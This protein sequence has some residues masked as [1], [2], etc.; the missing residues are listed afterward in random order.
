MVK[1]DIR[2]GGLRNSLGTATSSTLRRFSRILQS[3]GK[4]GLAFVSRTRD[5]SRLSGYAV[6]TPLCAD[7]A[8]RPSL[9]NWYEWSSNTSFTPPDL[10]NVVIDKLAEDTGT[11]IGTFA[12]AAK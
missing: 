12:R 3:A 1:T 8:H 4:C 10:L 9:C 5:A 6:V 2:C 7:S 11:H